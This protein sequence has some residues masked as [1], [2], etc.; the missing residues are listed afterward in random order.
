MISEQMKRLSTSAQHKHQTPG[1]R[2]GWG[3]DACLAE[4]CFWACVFMTLFATAAYSN[5]LVAPEFARQTCYMTSEQLIVSLTSKEAQLHGTFRFKTVLPS[6]NGFGYPI[7]LDVP[8]WLPEAKRADKSVA[9]ILKLFKEDGSY[10]YKT[11]LTAK[12]G[13]VLGI[14]AVL[15]K[16]PLSFGLV[17]KD[18]SMED[19][20]LQWPRAEGFECLI[21]RFYIEEHTSLINEQLLLSYRQPLLRKTGVAHFYYVPM[22]YNLPKGVFT[23]YPERYAITLVAKPDVSSLTFSNAARSVS[24]KGGERVAITPQHLKELQVEVKESLAKTSKPV[25]DRKSPQAARR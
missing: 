9:E 16:K 13:K 19:W 2:Q 22:F 3:M 14:R 18:T 20:A 4:V 17:F 21:L 5:P 24:I 7:Y 1:S 6:T 10:I 8:V 15:G 12:I 23:N 11:N 25:S